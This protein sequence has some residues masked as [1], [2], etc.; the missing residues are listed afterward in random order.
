M[1]DELVPLLKKKKLALFFTLGN[2]LHTWQS[3]GMLD[4]ELALYRSLSNFVDTIYFVTYQ[5][6]DL[7]LSS[8]LPKNIIVLPKKYAIPNFLYSLIVPFVYTNELRSCTW[9]KTNQLLGSWSAIIAKL[10]YRNRLIIRTGYTASQFY[11]RSN[12]GAYLFLARILEWFAIKI[13]DRFVVASEEDRR[14]LKNDT[15]M[16]VPNYVDTDFLSPANDSKNDHAPVLLFVG[17]LEVQKNLFALLEALKKIPD[18]TLQIVGSGSLKDEL[19]SVVKENILR[20]EFLGNIPFEQLKEHYLNASLFVLPS[21]YEG[22]PKVLLEAMSCGLPVVATNVIGIN[23]II[24]SEENG[25][26]CDLDSE[27][28]ATALRVV[29][30]DDVL[31]SRLRLNARKFIEDNF[32]L[33]SVLKKELR[34]YT[35]LLK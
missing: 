19:M 14:W 21:F 18:A 6:N 22:T 30:Q 24:K 23:T 27:S 17:R 31:Q 1:S 16:I 33:H 25:Y 15:V 12:K 20:V 29:L 10:L 7:E 32:S 26:L 2:G 9:L 5:T 8:L 34:M 3:V 4:R 28:I 13:A 35:Q 11:A